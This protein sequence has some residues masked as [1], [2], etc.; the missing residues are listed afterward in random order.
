MREFP[1]AEDFPP[2]P[3]TPYV[4]L[5]VLA[6]VVLGVFF[7][8]TNRK[9]RFYD[10]FFWVAMG[11]WLQYLFFAGAQEHERNRASLEQGISIVWILMLVA[12]LIGWVRLTRQK[13]P[14]YLVLGVS[15]AVGAMILLPNQ[16]S[17]PRGPSRYFSCKNNLHYIGLALEG[18]R[19]HESDWPQQQDGNP[20]HSWRVALLPYIDYAPL[21]HRYDFSAA[22]D[23]EANRPVTSSYISAY[24]CP[25][26]EAEHF[27]GQPFP[28][29][30]ALLIGDDAAWTTNGFIE[31]DDIPDG[32]SHTAILTEACGLGIIWTEPR[33]IDLAKTP[34]GIN[35]P[36][37]GP[38]H[39]PGVFST[40][41]PL[42]ANVLMADGSVR[43][44]W[45]DT[46]PAVLNAI[47]T[48]DG[49][50]EVPEF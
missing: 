33:D 26:S 45:L 28:T 8:R 38:G 39:S 30:Y 25:S 11:S 13:E 29:S 48:A 21:Y 19:D 44:L 20:P 41:H 2:P 27:E 14:R 5:T 50:D 35:L 10:A 12:C 17:A 3:L 40:Y 47:L 1:Q 22:W 16:P 37:N 32:S 9:V 31:P 36:G 43:T 24:L 49:G 15:L 42:G 34:V 46:D 4:A 18:Y 23:A 6:C 7:L